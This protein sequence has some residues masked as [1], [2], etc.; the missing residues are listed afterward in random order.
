MPET[1][2]PS[3]P[4]IPLANHK[5][6][7]VRST[8]LLPLLLLLL[9]AGDSP[10]VV[11]EDAKPGDHPLVGKT[12]TVKFRSGRVMKNVVIEMVFPGDIADTVARLRVRV[13]SSGSRPI[14]GA[15]SIDNITLANGEKLLVFEEK[16]RCLAPADEKKLAE[17]RQA[18]GELKGSSAKGK[19][20]SAR[21]TK[22]GKTRKYTAETEEERRKKNE[23][24]RKEFHKKTGVWLWP[25]LTEEQQA[26][27][28]AKA[29]ANL[30]I[31]SE[32]FAPLNMHLY[33]TKYY[34][35]LSDIPP[36]MVTLYTSCLD[37]M[38]DKLCHSF[39]VKYK[40]SVWIGGK[41]PVIAFVNAQSFV[42]FEKVFFKIDTPPTAQGLAHQISSGEVIISCHCGKDPY[43]F[44][45]VIV[46]EATHGFVFRY[47]SP[48]M[49][50]NWINEGIAEWVSMSVV[51][52][53]KGVQRKVKGSI[54]EMRQTG[55]VGPNFFTAKN[56][57]ANQYGT[58]TAMVDFMLR[59]NPKGFKAMLDDIKSGVK[60]EEALKKRF[61]ATP[62]ELTQAFGT[63]V[64]GI[65][66]LKP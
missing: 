25:E 26:E 62:E 2:S 23:E 14:L 33:E 41:A 60:W 54:A 61:K 20:N 50:P 64:V 11:G 5:P 27:G 8:R 55:T 30:K 37:K 22:P 63:S 49:I 6:M 19:P 24:K 44:A 35:F 7:H 36:Q 48:V 58:A 12:V 65:P 3:P 16:S 21:K 17:I 40:S 42:E 38:H 43:Y 45:G 32:K 4:A 1:I 46:H 13:P 47:K 18:A 66:M 52:S 31:V 34:L 28:L 29:K 59:S 51:K 53:N 57:A 15:S 56:I 39:G 10:L 9:L